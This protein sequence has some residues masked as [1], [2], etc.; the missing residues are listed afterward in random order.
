MFGVLKFLIWTCC[1]VGLGIFLA[2][3]EINGHPP[4]EHMERAWNRTIISSKPAKKPETYSDDERAAIDKLISN[5][6]RK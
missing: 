3:G 1:A 5:K 2:K 4:L 6:A